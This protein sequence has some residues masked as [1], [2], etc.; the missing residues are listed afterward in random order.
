MLGLKNVRLQIPDKRRPTV[1]NQKAAAIQFPP[2]NSILNEPFSLFGFL[3]IIAQWKTSYVT[4][5]LSPQSFSSH[6]KDRW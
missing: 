4:A 1:T 5:K 3:Q 6:L 2:C